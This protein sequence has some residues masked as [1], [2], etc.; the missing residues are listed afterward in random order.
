M[1]IPCEAFFFA[2]ARQ[3]P[4]RPRKT[5]ERDFSLVPRKRSREIDDPFEEPCRGGEGDKLSKI[6]GR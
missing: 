2:K 5:G 6:Q 1:L 3:S 4:A